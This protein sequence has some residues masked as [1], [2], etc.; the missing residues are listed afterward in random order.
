MDT[1]ISIV[2]VPCYNETPLRTYN[3]QGVINLSKITENHKKY[4]KFEE[5]LKIWLFMR[6]EICYSMQG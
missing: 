2:P 3:V 4:I 1:V 6:N 5:L